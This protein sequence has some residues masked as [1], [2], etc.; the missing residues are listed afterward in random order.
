MTPEDL[1][2]AILEAHARPGTQPADLF[3]IAR[4]ALDARAAE[5]REGRIDVS[6]EGIYQHVVGNKVC[7]E[8]WC[9][10]PGYPCACPCG[11][12]IHADFGDENDVGDYWVYVKCDRCGKPKG[13]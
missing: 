10:T 2:L 6:G 8:G 11:G 5:E 9:G 1:V 13:G 7:T 12:L 3:A 4:R